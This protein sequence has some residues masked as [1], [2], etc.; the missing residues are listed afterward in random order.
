MPTKDDAAT[1]EKQYLIDELDSRNSWRVFRIL[2]EFVDGFEE[3]TEHTRAVSLFGSARTKPDD[4]MYHL[5]EELGRRFAELGYA[6]L[7]GGGPGLMEAANKGASEA[8]GVSIG[9]NI[10]LPF[11]QES[12]PYANIQVSFRY[13]FVRKF[14]LVKYAQAFVILPGGFGTFDEFFESLM[15]IQTRK[16]KP[17]PVVLVGSEYWA[18][19]TKWVREVPLAHANISPEDPDLFTVLDDPAEIV[20]YVA[21]WDPTQSPIHDPEDP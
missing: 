18:G 1:S 14:M 21:N 20:D 11:E 10:E 13:F 19:L 6:V 2:A 8:G 4:P 16:I 17:F 12:N 3:M 5:A 7:T 9:L 15:L